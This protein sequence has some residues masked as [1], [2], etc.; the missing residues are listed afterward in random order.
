MILRL[1]FFLLT[2]TRSKP[3]PPRIL[4]FVKIF[5]VFFLKASLTATN[6]NKHFKGLFELLR[7]RE[8]FK[9]KCDTP[10]GGVWSGSMSHKK[11]IVSKS[12]LSNFKQF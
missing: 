12:F 2:W 3:P 4:T 10:E 6:Q 9:K 5:L 1:W 7:L 11:T 8:A